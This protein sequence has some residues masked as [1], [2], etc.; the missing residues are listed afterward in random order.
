MRFEEIIDAARKECKTLLSRRS[1]SV[2][3]P[4]GL[5]AARV[6]LKLAKKALMQLPENATKY[7]P[8]GEPITNSRVH[9]KFCEDERGRPGQLD[10]RF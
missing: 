6:G 9:W 1:I 3:L 2:Q 10:G 7:S 5:P 8:A 4:K